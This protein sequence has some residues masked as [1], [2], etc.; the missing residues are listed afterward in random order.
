M[1]V[2]APRWSLGAVLPR[3][4]RCSALRACGAGRLATDRSGRLARRAVDSW[5]SSRWQRRYRVRHRELSTVRRHG[6]CRT[7]VIGS[8]GE[9]LL[10]SA[11]SPVQR[12]RTDR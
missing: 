3:R 9:Q 2:A 7:V 11:I 5:L 1:S 10:R 4:F 12:T 6:R 8:G